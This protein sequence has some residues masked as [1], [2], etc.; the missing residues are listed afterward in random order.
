MKFQKFQPGLIFMILVILIMTACQPQIA[1]ENTP[2][3]I[4]ATEIIKTTTPTLEPPRSMVICLGDEPLTL[5]PYGSDSRA[6]WSVL[7]AIY[8]GPIDTVNFESQ[9]VILK[10][11][12]TLENGG[13]VTQA[14][15]VS[16]G[17]PVVDVNG[18][19][20]L[21][22][23]DTIVLPVGCQDD[24]CAIK[25]D[26]TTELQMTQLS[27]SFTMLDGLL[28]SDGQPLTMAD[29]VYSFHLAAD[30]STPV[31]RY[32]VERTADYSSTSD[33]T[34]TW[35]GVPGFYP[36]HFGDLFWIP[37]PQH[38]WQSK[39][40][41]ELLTDP[42]ATQTPI[43]WGPYQ[44]KEWVSGSHIELIPNPNYF[45]ASE[46]LPV[47]DTLVYQ[48]LGTTADSNLK[49][50]EIGECDLIDATV[51]LDEQLVDVVEKSNLGE[52]KAYFGQG[53]E[54]EHLDFGIVP[55]S[56][57]DGI[58]MNS[59]RADWFGDLRMRQAFAYCIDRQAIADRYFVNRSE[60]PTSFYPPS[61][62]LFDGS[63]SAIAYD[64][65]KGTA[66]LEEMGWMDEDQNPSTP[67]I[68]RNVANVVDGTP[69]SINYFTTQ[70]DLR[71]LVSNDIK[72]SVA[73][74]GIELNVLNIFPSE[75]YASG[76]EGVL[77]G[78]NFDLAQ[79]TWQAGRD[80]PC[81]LYTTKQIP[82]EAN[83]WIG[84]NITGYQ[85]P[86]YDQACGLAQQKQPVDPALYMEANQKIQQIFAEDMPVLPLYYQIKIAA[87][88]PDF[89]GLDALDVSSRS[90]L[91]ALET[92]NYGEN[93]KNP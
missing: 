92:F 46:N 79:F 35:V 15:T 27:L 44:I 57:D 21:L 54:W 8:D 85:N 26:G 70:S 89:C 78:R 6:M 56:Y 12:P 37:L 59:D 80:T 55:A 75:L 74:C 88:R 45:R 28:W 39:T 43:G 3:P 90:V 53:P 36:Q 64:V 25:W 31:N 47:F 82:N 68:A 38:A 34:L 1:I 71:V 10:D 66:L 62:P 7:E 86:D 41:A 58:Q 2:S 33:T 84:T 73:V 9:P 16:A 87:S 60:V 49:A 77:F 19:L 72:N 40:A 67:R 76:P 24:T 22:V 48:F 14:V 17:D 52:I 23:K 65:E 63:L 51:S 83:M 91:R 18:D 42:A 81:Y 20:V 50:L 69:L 5:Y 11:L 29:S 13:A 30:P 61:H 32:H 93:C 4:V